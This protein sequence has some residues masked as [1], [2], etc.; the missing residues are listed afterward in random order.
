VT[1]R[2]GTGTVGVVL[3]TLFI[4][5]L[6]AC[7]ATVRIGIVVGPKGAGTVSVTASLD[8][9]AAA[10]VPDL[11]QTL[12][13][14]DLRQAGWRIDGPSPVPGGGMTVVVTKAFSTPAEAVQVLGELSGPTGPFRDL[15]LVR[16]TSLLGTTTTFT[17]TVDLTCGLACFG[18]PQ[19]QQTLGAN[20]GLDPTKLQQ[21]G[22]DPAQILT[23]EVGVRLPGTLQSSNAAARAHGE[24]QWV[25]KLGA[26]G[27]VDTSSRIAHHDR[28]VQIEVVVAVVVVLLLG[29]A[30]WLLLRRR[31]RRKRDDRGGGR[32]RPLHLAKG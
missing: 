9:D 13:T 17:G 5:C 14:A 6:S 26:K 27:T 10:A 31:R 8:H 12:R 18:D 7:Q 22:I 2:A 19:L 3:A 15:N 32:S 23:F 29:L 4:L 28:L 20:L 30:T 24:S 25:F 1:K 11:A 21:A 16:D